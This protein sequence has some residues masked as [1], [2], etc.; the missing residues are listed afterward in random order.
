MAKTTDAP[1]VREALAEVE[2][3]LRDLG[4]FDEGER[5][6]FEQQSPRYAF[7]LQFLSNQASV[8]CELLDVG[9]HVLHFSM[10][11]S[12]LGYRVHGSDIAIFVED[13]RNRERQ[14]RCGVLEMRACDLSSASL[15]YD[16]GS[17][18]VVNFTETIEHFNFNPLP[19][20]QEIHRV[21]K[22]G[23]LVLVT[24]PNATRLGN[25]VRFLLG[26]TVFTDIRELC[27]G[28]AHELHYREY[29]LWE[30]TAVLQWA[31]FTIHTQRALFLYPDSVLRTTLKS[32]IMR[33]MP[34]LGGT[35]FVAGIK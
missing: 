10:A 17:F 3:I 20:L 2:R 26:K 27:F 6:Y 34:A 14:E 16:S 18:D 24:T 13:P 9:S 28:A 15:P 12:L 19:V 32:L 29:M 31:G 33:L 30:L 4:W 25:R 5:V 21:L 7:L 35:L 23:G 11:A 1:H 8:P 22:P